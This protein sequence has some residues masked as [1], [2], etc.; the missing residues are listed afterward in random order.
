MLVNLHFVTIFVLVVV[1]I[2]KTGTEA[3][4]KTPK[5]VHPLKL[6]ILALRP[7]PMGWRQIFIEKYPEYNTLQGLTRLSNVAATNASVT[8]KDITEKMELLFRK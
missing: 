7:L 5:E 3:T 8:D 1:K 6:R 2:M 4:R